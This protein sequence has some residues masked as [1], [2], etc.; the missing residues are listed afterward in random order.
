MKKRVVVLSGAGI[1]AESGLD[2]FR[3]SNGLWANYR[4]EDVCT[5]DALARNPERVLDFYNMRRRQ[6][7]RVE[8]NDAHRALVDLER[9]FQV[10]IVTQ[11]IDDLHERAGSSNVLHLHGELLKSRSIKNPDI[12]VETRG[13]VSL[14]DCAPD[15]AQ[16]RPHVV[17]FGE[18]VPE[19]ERGA[20]IVSLAEIFIVVGTSLAVYPAAGLVNYVPY[21]VPCFLVDPTDVNASYRVFKYI[22]KR[23]SEGLPELCSLLISNF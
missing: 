3:D 2:T 13:D 4:I 7:L 23:A 8:P 5:P 9:N 1:S 10:D 16:L 19:L 14:G 18:E 22:K 20:K 12:I 17:F 11:N 21:G 6:L 15:G